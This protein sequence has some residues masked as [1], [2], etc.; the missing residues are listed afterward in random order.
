MTF[1]FKLDLD[2]MVIYLLIMNEVNRSN[3]LSYALKILKN[4]SHDVCHLDFDPITLDL[5][6]G[7]D[8]VLTYIHAKN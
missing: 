6:L 3:G 5:K 7:L 8:M 1:T 2:I 4:F